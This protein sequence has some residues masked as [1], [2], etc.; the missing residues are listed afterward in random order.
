MEGDFAVLKELFESTDG[1]NWRTKGN[2][3]DASTT[4]WDNVTV[5]GD[6]GRVT[7]LVLYNLKLG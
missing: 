3:L 4:E 2:W 7:D 5:D 6:S 1:P